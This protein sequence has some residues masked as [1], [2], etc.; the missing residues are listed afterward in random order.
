MGEVLRGGGGG[1][2][3]GICVAYMSSRVLLAVRAQGFRWLRVDLGDCVN[4]VAKTVLGT[5]CP[6]LV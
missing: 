5:F 4:G 6:N 3:L 2:D 1:A